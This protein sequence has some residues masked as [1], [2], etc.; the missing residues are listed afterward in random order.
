MIFHDL[1][2]SLDKVNSTEQSLSSQAN[3]SSPS[4]EI[5]GILSTPKVYY[6]VD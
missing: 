6:R 5:T 4:N 1:Y 3:N 2:S